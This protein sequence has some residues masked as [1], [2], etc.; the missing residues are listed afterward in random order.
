MAA[1]LYSFFRLSHFNQ[2]KMIHKILIQITTKL[3]KHG[4]FWSIKTFFGCWNCRISSV[5]LFHNWYFSRSISKVR[6]SVC[7]KNHDLKILFW[8]DRTIG[9]I[10]FKICRFD[11]KK[12]SNLLFKCYNLLTILCWAATKASSCTDIEVLH[13][14]DMS[15]VL[16]ETISSVR[17]FA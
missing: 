7:F 1:E 11:I 10:L 4:T 17:V 9:E 13:I 2:T 3:V 14:K 16:Y 12:C 5:C 8:I 15:P 6:K